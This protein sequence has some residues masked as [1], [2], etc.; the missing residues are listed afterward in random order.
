MEIL[1]RKKKP[2]D[3]LDHLNLSI[4][5]GEI[6]KS[7]EEEI[8]D[9]MRHLV[10]RVQQRQG[11]PKRL[12][13]VSAL[14]QE[15]VSYISQALAATIA[16]DLN[17]R[18]C[19]VDLNFWWS[20]E[21]FHTDSNQFSLARA[22]G[23]DILFEE[24]LCQ[25]SFP[26]LQLLPSG[27]FPRHKRHV[28]AKSEA[29]DEIILDLSSFY[30]HLILDIPAILATSESATLASLGNAACLVI[31]QGVTQVG[32]VSQAL[33]EINHLEMIGSVLN[34]VHVS[35]PKPILKLLTNW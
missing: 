28:W 9:E 4:R 14:R 23:G 33:D 21:I 22:L 29:L 20:D 3:D 24:A 35:T 30:D 5:G 25:T 31:R 1:K 6:Q 17:Q 2:G 16:H 27:E 32:E 19:L 15:G 13:V 8:I 34:Q 10:T 7:F 11:F 18:I 12:S 26:N